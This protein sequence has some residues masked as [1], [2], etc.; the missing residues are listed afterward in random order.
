MQ[1]F[2]DQIWLEKNISYDSL[3]DPPAAPCE[4]NQVPADVLLLYL[5]EAVDETVWSLSNE[6]NSNPG[7][8][9]FPLSNEFI[10]NLRI[11]KFILIAKSNVI[12][13]LSQPELVDS[14]FQSDYDYYNPGCYLCQFIIL[15][16]LQSLLDY[17]AFQSYHQDPGYYISNFIPSQTH[18]ND[19]TFQNYG[20]NEVVYPFSQLNLGNSTFQSVNYSEGCYNNGLTEVSRECSSVSSK[21][22]S[23]YGKISA[24]KTRSRPCKWYG[25]AHECLISFLTKHIVDVKNLEKRNGDGTKQKLWKDA[26]DELR[27]E[28]HDFSSVQCCTKWKNIKQNFNIWKNTIQNKSDKKDENKI[29]IEEILDNEEQKLSCKRKVMTDEEDRPKVYK[30]VPASQKRRKTT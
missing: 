2:N 20:Y 21:P 5:L 23:S 18:L 14:I 1:D 7:Y 27:K 17:S 19:S 3:I 22:R 26:S 4:T 6:N 29:N 8:Y 30:F 15:P 11:E 9:K 13:P 16:Q 25:K 10:I 12:L 28:G 24:K